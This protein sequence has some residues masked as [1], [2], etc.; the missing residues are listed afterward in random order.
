MR[1]T[2]AAVLLVTP[3]IA[4]A[5]NDSIVTLGIGSHTVV[6][7]FSG[8]TPTVGTA[9]SVGQGFSARLR[10]LYVLGAEFA[11]DLTGSR[12]ASEI[13][14]P[15]P[16]FKLS[17]LVYLIPQRQFSLFLLGGLGATSAGDLF[18]TSGA[19]SSYHGGIGFEVGITRNWIFAADFRVN[20]PAY[21]QAIE[22]GKRDAFEKGDMPSI[23]NYYNLDSWQLNVGV[24][25][26][27]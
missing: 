18:S 4:F 2:L 16:T 9:T 24:R 20:L 3:S 19:T 10:L 6:S 7:R 1:Q 22:R 17:G 8:A 25:Y 13:N 12:N 21:S 11:Y 14:V 27:L 15:V 26:Y 5:G 23:S